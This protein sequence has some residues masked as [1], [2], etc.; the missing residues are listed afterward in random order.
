MNELEDFLDEVLQMD[1]NIQAEDSSPYQA[2][3]G[4]WGA[5]GGGR[6]ARPAQGRGA[7]AA[8]GMGSARGGASC[9]DAGPVADGSPP[10]TQIARSLINMHQQVA[11]GDYSYVQHLRSIPQPNTAACP[12]EANGELGA[13]EES[14]SSDEEEW[15]QEGPKAMDAEVRR[16]RWLLMSRKKHYVA[17]VFLRFPL[18]SSACCSADAQIRRAA[19]TWIWMRLQHIQHRRRKWW[20]RTAFRSSCGG[21]ADDECPLHPTL[22]CSFLLECECLSRTLRK[23]GWV[24]DGDCGGGGGGGGLGN[25][26]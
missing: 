25:Q 5:A 12:R 6:L 22:S 4:A 11:S 10:P 20:T 17:A 26:C 1:F 3:S 21:R 7:S 8:A 9:G 2:S 19:R 24:G 16:G 23:G 15:A 18:L 13:D 14:S